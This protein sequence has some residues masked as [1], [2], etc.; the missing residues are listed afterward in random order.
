MTGYA[1]SVRLAK[2]ESAEHGGGETRLEQLLTTDQAA[3]LLQ[4]P[5]G[6]LVD[7]R[8]RGAGP[9]YIRCEGAVRYRVRDL[10]RWLDANSVPTKA[11]VPA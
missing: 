8:Y 4:K 7:W 10:E 1:D 6:T 5:T 11:Q 2:T 3:E 9:S